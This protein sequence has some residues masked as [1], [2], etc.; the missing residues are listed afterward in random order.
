MNNTSIGWTEKTLNV[1]SGCN[2]VSP[3]CKFC[4]AKTL[5]ERFSGT[6]AFPNGF[7]LTVREHRITEPYKLKKPTLIFVNS[8]SDFFLESVPDEL[9]DRVVDA[10]E[11]TPQ[12]QYQVLTKRPDAMLRYSRR[13][14][15]P[16]NFWAGVSVETQCFTRRVDILREVDAKI[17][18]I[19]AEPLLSPLTLNLDGIHWVIAGGESGHH[20][21]DSEIRAKRALVDY[22][23]K[24]KKWRPRQDRY[25]WI[26]A[27]RDHCLEAKV[28]FFFKQWGGA[29]SKSAGNTLDDR[30]WED[31]PRF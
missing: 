12:H 19:S 10:I 13:R 18:F 26:T 24:N 2:K 30:K 29:N 17:R 7:D 9:R 1:W 20:L 28:A 4:F 31:F 3:G 6:K 11:Q 27:L 16:D 14:K 25:Y 22:D 8:M 15:L 23:S 5:A 21:S